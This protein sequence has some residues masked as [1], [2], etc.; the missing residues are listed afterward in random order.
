MRNEY[1][2]KVI[3]LVADM[4]D[5]EN[6]VDILGF[7]KALISSGVKVVRIGDGVLPLTNLHMAKFYNEIQ[8]STE[9][10]TLIID[11]HGGLPPKEMEHLF[12][13]VPLYQR[14]ATCLTSARP[15]LQLTA[16]LFTE[17]NKCLRGRPI[18]I[19]LAA[20]YAGVMHE[21]VRELLPS[22][23]DLFFIKCRCYAKSWF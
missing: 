11:A 4:G 10:L 8:S 5:A 7:E 20:C 16:K 6:D 13:N 9:N 18:D 23:S 17:I 21:G 19:L 12:Q 1:K 2:R 14:H 3:F 15:S 22:G